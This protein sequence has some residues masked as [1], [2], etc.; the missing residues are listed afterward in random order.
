ARTTSAATSWPG[1]M[2]LTATGR[3]STASWPCHT[4]DIP[5]RPIRRTSRYLPPRVRVAMTGAVPGGDPAQTLYSN[6]VWRYSFANDALWT[7]VRPRLHL[8]G[9]ARVRLGIARLLRGRRRGDHR[10]AV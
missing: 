4:S 2:T 6:T 9:R 3:S 7:D 8:P 5:P 10:G 1:A